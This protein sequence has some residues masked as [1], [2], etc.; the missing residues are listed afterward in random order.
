MSLLRIILWSL[1]IYLVLRTVK[2][3]AKVL[4]WNKSNSPKRETVKKSESK[5]RIKKEDVI[6]AEYEEITDSDSN[7]TKK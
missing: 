2:N 3:V 4:G 7:K 5:Y 1:I 6:E